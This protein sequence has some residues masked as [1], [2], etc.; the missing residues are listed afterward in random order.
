MQGR[1]EAEEKTKEHIND[2]LLDSPK[3]LYDWYMHLLAQGV[4]AKSC[5]DFVNKV[6]R[7]LAFIHYD[8]TEIQLDEIT[9]TDLASYFVSIQYRIGADGKKIRTSESYR[10]GIWFALNNFFEYQLTVGNVQNS[11]MST[12]KPKQKKKR[13]EKA[14]RKQKPLLTTSDFNKMLAHI[15]GKNE[16]IRS[17]NKAILLLY[18]NTGMRREALCQI[19]IDDIDINKHQLI[20]IDKGDYELTYDLN[21]PTFNAIQSWIAL[22]TEFVNEQTNDA[23]FISYLGQRI[24]GTAIYDMIQETSFKALGYKISPHRLRSGLCSILYEQ[25]HDIEFV[26]RTIGHAKATTTQRY[27]ITKDDEQKQA[28]E[29]LENILVF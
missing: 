24:S 2:K 3:Y 1:I 11:Y 9:P 19:D 10:N 16:A 23:L 13:E 6:Q 7:F 27:I 17:R 26:R 14:P 22:R 12:V 21:T 5:L 25:T 15:P 20:I 29:I 28:S 8:L 18:M 4:T